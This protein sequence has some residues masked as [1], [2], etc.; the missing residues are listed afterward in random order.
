MHSLIIP[1]PRADSIDD[2]AVSRHQRYFYVLNVKM[3]ESIRNAS[4]DIHIPLFHFFILSVGVEWGRQE[5][6]G[7]ENW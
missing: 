3:S 1:R 4:V 7:E 6:S 5:K 2:S